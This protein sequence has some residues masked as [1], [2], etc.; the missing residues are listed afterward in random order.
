MDPEA[1]R[2]RKIIEKQKQL[3]ICKY[4]IQQTLNKFV[5]F[6]FCVHLRCEKK[7]KTCDNLLK[8]MA[9]K[10]EERKKKEQIQKARR[11]SDYQLKK[12]S[13]LK[14]EPIIAEVSIH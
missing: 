13:E 10:E 7:K 14:F 1:E 8:A 5:D 12:L 3:E 9:K 2:L 4:L 11:L 6:F